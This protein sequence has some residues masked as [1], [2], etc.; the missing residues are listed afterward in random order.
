MKTLKNY[1]LI[2]EFE[3]RIF[4]SLSIVIASCLICFGYFPD[5]PPLFRQILKE[6]SL[7]KVPSSAVFITAAFLMIVVS[8]L[9]MWAG[10]A[11]SSEIVM[12]FKVRTDILNR[13]GPYKLVRNPIYLADWIAI[14]VFTFFLHPVGIVMPVLFYIHYV[15]LIVYEEESLGVQYS[16]EYNSYLNCVPRF[17][18][19]YT[20][21]SDFLPELKKI[22]VNFDG[23]RHNA[24]YTMFVPG[25]IAAAYYDSFIYAMIIGIPAVIDWAVV[26][27]EIGVGKKKK[28]NKKVFEGVLYAQC[29]EDPAIDRAAFNIKSGDTVFTITSGGCNALAFLLDNPKK[30]IALDLNPHQN[31]LF[32]LKIAAMKRLSYDEVLQLLGI[33]DSDSRVSLYQAS[34]DL[35]SNKAQD[36]WDNHLK[37]IKKGLIHCGRYESYMRLLRK[38]LILLIG[39]K[40]MKALF[41][42]PSQSERKMIYE[43]NWDNIGWKIFT[44][45]FL[46]RKVMS[47]LFTDEFFKYLGNRFS[48]GDNFARKVKRAITELPVAENYFLSYILLGNYM[49]NNFPPYLQRDNYEIIL[50]RLNRI[51]IVTADCEQY[52]IGL[53]DSCIDKFN[54]TNIFEW[55]SP[56]QFNKLLVQTIRTAKDKSIITYRN[57]LVPRIHPPSLNNRIELKEE[58]SAIL[59]KR[60]LSFIYDRYVVE[61]INKKEESCHL[62][63]VESQTKDTSM[64][65]SGCHSGSMRETPAGSR[66]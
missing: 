8:L 57:L 20:S 52:F 32:E 15:R 17:L 27:T 44:R 19:N 51:E 28:K 63:L 66:R 13:E 34:R 61:Q 10:T 58:L 2:T 56:E 31:Y 30:I 18:P 46:S 60:D 64:N 4:I 36:F 49:Q 50:G 14:S 48:F 3:Y 42:S 12:T 55:I 33:R 23:F 53:P 5:T 16:E 41:A 38:I 39:K 45:I 6:I 37:E 22:K 26:H 65:L 62:S 9:R 25:F 21:L 24:L 7:N 59:H 35:L 54:F 29:W 43:R 40:V 47:F 11:L 1:L